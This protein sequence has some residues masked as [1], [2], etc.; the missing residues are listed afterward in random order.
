MSTE[1]ETQRTPVASTAVELDPFDPRDLPFSA[2]DDGATELP[3]H[4]R[5]QWDERPAV[6]VHTE[7]WCVDYQE[8]ADTTWHQRGEECT[9]FAL[10]AI[11]DYHLRKEYIARTGLTA[12]QWRRLPLAEREQQTAS[13]R[14]MY[15]MA[16]VYDRQE[17]EQGSTLRGALKGWQDS[18]VA[19]AKVWPYAPDDEKGE[20]H[21]RLGL[22]R[23]VDSIARPGGWYF[24]I[25]KAD[26]G[27]MKLALARNY[28]LFASAVQHTGWFELY[29]PDPPRET[30]GEPTGSDASKPQPM[31]ACI[32]RPADLKLK[33]GHAFVIV[34]YD[35]VGW[36]IHNSWGPDWGD[37][38]YAVLPYDDWA[39]LGQDVWF[40]FPPDVRKKRL[41]T[42]DEFLPDSVS[43]RARSR[44]DRAEVGLLQAESNVALAECRVDVSP[45]GPCNDTVPS[46]SATVPVADE[47]DAAAVVVERAR[48][49][50]ATAQ[51]DL[52]QAPDCAELHS[53]MWRHVV[54]LGDD[55]RLLPVGTR[56]GMN[57]STLKTMV[58][59]FRHQ[60]REWGMRRLAIFADGGYWSTPT[61]VEQLRPLCD[62][63]MTAEIYPIFLLWDTPW[64]ADMHGWLYGNAG[65]DPPPRVA[66][67]NG[68]NGPD[69]AVDVEVAVKANAAEFPAP[70]MWR[71]MVRR[72]RAA[73]GLVDGGGRLLVDSVYYNRTKAPF[74]VHLLGHGVGELL[75]PQLAAMLP[76]VASCNLWAPVSTMDS[77]RTSYARM[78]DSRHLRHLTIHALDDR[79]ELDDSMGPLRGSPLK[80]LS[81]V[82]DAGNLN[83][84][85]VV[86]GLDR[87]ERWWPRPEP[88]LGMQR[89]LTTDDEV[90]RLIGR[91]L[92]TTNFVARPSQP[93]W[94]SAHTA[95]LTDEAVRDVTIGS[96]LESSAE[97]EEVDGSD[98]P[99]PAPTADPVRPPAPA[100]RPVPP[101]RAVPVD[102][103]RGPDPL[104]RR[105]L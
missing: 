99:P 20:K 10:A 11:A 2:L 69:A 95:L 38:G 62:A 58:W 80:L 90:E 23:V 78:L 52:E 57:H 93:P 59:M 6:E 103:L 72:A 17:F 74:E 94:E 97:R 75:L 60:R 67:A 35:R 41:I 26:V 32:R 77:F 56:Y 53:H 33:G 102:A 100:P 45:P 18:G 42:E 15:E 22:R 36:R 48:R 29:L 89:Y 104:V 21:G 44:V 25:D 86:E 92:L 54:T 8:L 7:W 88:I 55:G 51:R 85:R 30:H 24:R 12:E 31:S 47:I 9:G 16:Q 43:A 63:M 79:S 68:G 91:E 96:I 46:A 73:C 4:I 27:S 5:R 39:D 64:Y 87:G 1:A 76:P 66:S 13:R 71:Q 101:S 83:V 49:E 3:E 19:S 105:T 61:A 70:R 65:I 50:L 40:A 37:D 82:L 34:G 14:M 28:P 98:L 81:D 84:S